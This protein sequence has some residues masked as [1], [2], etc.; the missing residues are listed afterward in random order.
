M[1]ENCLYFLYCGVLHDEDNNKTVKFPQSLMII[2]YEDGYVFMLLNS[3]Y[4]P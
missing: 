4:I 1:F 3:I 2:T